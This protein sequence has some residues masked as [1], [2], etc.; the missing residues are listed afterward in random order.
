VGR[1]IEELGAGG[2]AA[3]GVQLEPGLV[4]RLLTYSRTVAHFPTAVKEVRAMVG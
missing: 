3:L 1:L 2:A 4:E